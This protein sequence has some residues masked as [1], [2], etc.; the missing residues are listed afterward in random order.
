MLETIGAVK[1][2]SENSPCNQCG[3]GN[4]EYCPNFQR[5]TLYAAWVNACW[6]DFQRGA[7]RLRR[8]TEHGNGSR[9]PRA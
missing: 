7:E 2:G 5:C 4:R 8:L 6:E 1:G 3:C 9:K